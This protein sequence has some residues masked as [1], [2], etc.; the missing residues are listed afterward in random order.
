LFWDV[1]SEK[2]IGSIN[3]FKGGSALS[4]ALSQDGKNLAV[5][6]TGSSEVQVWKIASQLTKEQGK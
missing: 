1:G 2:Q 6:G 5:V 4:F 3:G